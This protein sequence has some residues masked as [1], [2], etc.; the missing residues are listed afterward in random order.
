MIRDE[1]GYE[2]DDD[3]FYDDDDLCDCPGCAPRI[4]DLWED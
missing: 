2:Y 1:Y 4:A 3:L